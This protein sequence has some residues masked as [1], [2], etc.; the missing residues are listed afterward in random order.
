MP[1]SGCPAV[2]ASLLI[3]NVCVGLTSVS[4][5]LQ[6]ESMRVFNRKVFFSWKSLLSNELE[7]T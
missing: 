2:L 4:P 7:Y 3:I 6:F 5:F 1:V